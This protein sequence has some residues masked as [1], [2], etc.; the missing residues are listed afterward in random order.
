MLY[1][2]S[3]I[4]TGN[5]MFKGLRVEGWGKGHVRYRGRVS[6]LTLGRYT[7]IHPEYFITICSFSYGLYFFLSLLLSIGSAHLSGE[8]YD[9][10]AS[11]LRGNVI[12]ENWDTFTIFMQK[13]RL[14]KFLFGI[15]LKWKNFI[16][17][18]R[19]FPTLIIW[20]YYYYYFFTSFS[21]IKWHQNK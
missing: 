6:R 10:Y 14:G 16:F 12:P 21:R 18:S 2:H 15:C 7:A 4:S 5:E 3:S 1:V 17:T 13:R 9:S 8:S 19:P 20:Y 11:Y